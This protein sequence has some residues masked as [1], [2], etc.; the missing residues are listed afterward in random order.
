[1]VW[2]TLQ[3]SY[4]YNFNYYHKILKYTYVTF[5]VLVSIFLLIRIY[6]VITQEI[7]LDFP[8][9]CLPDKGWAQVALNF[10]YRNENIDMSN[11]LTINQ[12]VVSDSKVYSI[13]QNCIN[14]EF[15]SSILY[16]RLKSDNRTTFFHANFA[17]LFF[18]F[19]DDM[20][21]GKFIENLRK[22]E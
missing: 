6:N 20:F 1:M 2:Q 22:W 17:S 14:E 19:I 3:Q 4:N 12:N 8:A 15:Q 7:V 11:V 13:I 21:I 10:N 16:Q 18:G 9:T 5:V